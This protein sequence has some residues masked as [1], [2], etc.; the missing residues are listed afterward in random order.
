MKP[1]CWP[2]EWASPSS[3][4]KMMMG[5][6]LFGFDRRLYVQ[7]RRQVAERRRDAIAPWQQ[8]SESLALR[9]SVAAIIQREMRWPNSLFIDEDPCSILFFDPLHHMD[10]TRAILYIEKAHGRNSILEK[11]SQITFGML[12]AALSEKT[13]KGTT[14]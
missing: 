1:L 4:Q 10:S 9:E 3:F 14:V 11:I 6:P 2:P 7:F 12:V 8:G 5:M 13:V